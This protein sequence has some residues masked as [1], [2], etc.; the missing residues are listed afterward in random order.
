MEIV[1]YGVI[2]STYNEAGRLAPGFPDGDCLFLA[3]CQTAGRG[4][5]DHVFES[6]AGNGIYAT[7]LVKRDFGPAD[8]VFS[9]F[10]TA[11]A[12][13]CIT[14]AVSDITGFGDR[15]SVKPVN[16]LMLDGRKYGGIL[17]ASSVTDG[18]T[19]AVRI[20]FG[21]NLGDA[22]LPDIAVSL[23]L[24]KAGTAEIR[25]LSDKLAIASA[26]M[27][28]GVLKRKAA[29]CESQLASADGQAAEIRSTSGC[30]LPSDDEAAAEYVRLCER[31]SEQINHIK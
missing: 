25:Q 26:E 30:A 28:A 20:G 1:R 19:R 23:S 13:V 3:D 7:L 6:P 27:I 15:L 18:R 17:C 4:Q 16:D 2:D 14:R 12:A 22:P 21:V 5:G 31:Y 11:L 24:G 29:D 10:V 8:P 9:S